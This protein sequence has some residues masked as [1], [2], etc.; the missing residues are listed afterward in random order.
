M[1]DPLIFSPDETESRPDLPSLR[2]RILEESLSASRFQRES[3]SKSTKRP[4]WTKRPQ[5]G[6]LQSTF[7]S[8]D[9][10][11]KLRPSRASQKDSIPWRAGHSPLMPS[12][13]KSE[14]ARG[15]E[16]EKRRQV[17]AIGESQEGALS[18][19]DLSPGFQL[20][21]ADPMMAELDCLRQTPTTRE[22]RQDIYGVSKSNGPSLLDFMEEDLIQDAE[23][24]MLLQPETRPI[25]HEQLVV[26]AKGMSDVQRFSSWVLQILIQIQGIYAG[27]VM[28][29]AKCIDIDER[30]SMGDTELQ[31]DHWNLLI[32]LHKQLLHEQHDFF[33][34]SQHPSAS[35]ALSRLTMKYSMP[36]R[37]WK[38][39]IQSYLDL[40]CQNGS[41]SIDD[42][43]AFLVETYSMLSQLVE[44]VPSM[45]D[46][47]KQMM[48][49]L[50]EYDEILKDLD[51]QEQ[52]ACGNRFPFTEPSGLASNSQHTMWKDPP[53]D[54]SEFEFG[55]CYIHNIDYTSPLERIYAH[56]GSRVGQL[57]M[58]DSVTN[59]LTGW[60]Y[61][62]QSI[63]SH[64]FNVYSKVFM[65]M[66]LAASKYAKW[67]TLVVGDN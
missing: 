57:K 30:A 5:F 51:R 14:R 48:K 62:G 49:A 64:S 24:E 56:L 42:M 47:W 28:V 60:L 25:S 19:N 44:S 8:T 11:R 3:E 38:R 26:E 41:G 35:P 45:M 32:A 13:T 36:T 59:T 46:G 15:N 65:A 9:N 66:S 20:P 31:S 12:D 27:L 54:P 63:A 18:Q 34:A 53:R 40:H 2:S 39:G 55:D 23:P 22:T 16:P 7:D 67:T 17:S 58:P 43:R 61:F 21:V 52:S 4:T 33:L 6:R 50:E 29:E 37:M 10:M 1:T